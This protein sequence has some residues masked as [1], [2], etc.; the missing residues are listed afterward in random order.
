MSKCTSGSGKGSNGGAN[1]DAASDHNREQQLNTNNDR[2]WQ[3]RGEESRPVDWEDRAKS[4][5]Q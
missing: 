3:S 5:G 4:A 2:Y 1:R